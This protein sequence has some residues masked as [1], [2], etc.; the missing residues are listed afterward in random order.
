MSEIRFGTDGWRAV[1]GDQFTFENLR[2]VAVASAHY[3]NNKRKENIPIKSKSTLLVGYDNRFL[4]EEFA[5]EVVQIFNHF[6]FKTILSEGAIPTPVLSHAVVKRGALGGVI[7]T[8]SHNPPVFNGFKIKMHFGASAP[9]EE[10]KQIEALADSS[11]PEGPVIK[12]AKII[13]SSFYGSYDK[14]LAKFV[15]INKIRRSEV[16]CVVDPIHGTGAGVL[17]RIVRS[18]HMISIRSC[19][20]P[21]FGGVNPE[22][23]Y[24]NLGELIKTVKA[25]KNTIGIAFDGDA[26]R[27]GMVDEKGN[28]VNSHQIFGLLV[29]H[30]AEHKKKKGKIVKTIS[31][32]YMVNRLAGQFG[33][34]VTETPIGFKHITEQMLYGDV[35]IGGEESG[36]IGFA[37]HI[38][39]RDGILSALYI[40]DLMTKTGKS[41]HELTKILSKRAGPSFYDRVD[42][43]LSHSISRDAFASSVKKQYRRILH[44]KP[45]EIKDYDGIKFIWRDDSW[46]LLRI[47]GTEPVVRIYAEAPS[48]AKTQK[49]L[50]LG[51]QFQYNQ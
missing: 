41:L 45:Q 14:D 25:R 16:S 46:L 39:E 47:S 29:L 32:T 48:K 33:M 42:Q 8:A 27:I 15:D 24:S 10:T 51:K 43:H 18:A 20:D 30:L 28:F 50:A 6:K 12:Q 7:I 49:L 35:M 34:D 22:P 13:R 4:S 9:I 38:P 11:L 17:E 44:E 26:D 23:I 2:K 19:R 40:L 36:G 5:L 31:S 37:G 21:L 3:F 1:I